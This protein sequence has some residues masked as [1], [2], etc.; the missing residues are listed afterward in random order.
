MKVNPKIGI[1]E[2]SLRSK[3]RS[4]LREIWRATSRKKFL[5]DI[6]IPHTGSGRNKYDV[7]CFKCGKVMGFSE[8]ALFLKANGEPRKKKTLVYQ[9]D[10][11]HGNPPF[12][13]LERDLGAYAQS[14]IYGEMRVACYQCHT[15]ITKNQRS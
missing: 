6:R 5:E 14:L 7:V 3:I 9:V 10:H 11:N 2:A 12:L 13:D 4:A 1:T 15:K 8:K